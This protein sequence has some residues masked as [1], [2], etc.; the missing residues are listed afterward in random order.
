[1]RPAHHWHE[2]TEGRPEAATDDRRLTLPGGRFLAIKGKSLENRHNT[3]RHL[4]GMFMRPGPGN[5]G[6]DSSVTTCAVL[7]VIVCS[8]KPAENKRRRLQ[9]GSRLKGAISR[10]TSGCEIVLQ[11][12]APEIRT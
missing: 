5:V 4:L 2:G 6:A 7:S 3:A 11:E 10:L 12:P 1:M 8:C 9:A